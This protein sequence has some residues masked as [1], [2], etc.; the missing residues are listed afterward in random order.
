MTN[1]LFEHE[2]RQ[3]SPDGEVHVADVKAHNRLVEQQELEEWKAKPD[4]FVGY[5]V[6]DKFTTWL[7]TEL[8]TV[9]KRVKI[10]TSVTCWMTHYRIRGNNGASYYGKHGDM[11]L[12]RVKRFAD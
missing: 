1:Y 7:G 4:R 10:R 3:F 8:G 5:I 11:Q 9:Y 6:G 12:L 2:G